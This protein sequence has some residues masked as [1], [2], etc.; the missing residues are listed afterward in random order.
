[1]T[2]LRQRMIEDMGVRNLSPRTQ[3]LYVNGVAKFAQYFGK[4]PERLGPEDIRTYQV[5]LVYEKHLSWS[6]FNGAVCALR[7]L[8][9]VTLGKDWAI[10]RIPFGKIERKLPIVL[11]RSEVEAFLNALTNI[12]YRAILMTAYATGLR[13][14]EV[15]CLRVS[16]IDSRRMVVRVEQGKGRKDRYVM[17][18]PKLLTF[19]REYYRV[20]RP[21]DW[22]FPGRIPGR[23]ITAMVVRRGYQ[24]ARAASGIRKKV[25]VRALR[26]SFATHL[27]EDGN[28][29]RTIQILLGHRSLQTTARYTHVS[30]KTVCAT[31]SPLDSL[32]G[33]H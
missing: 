3:R 16:D 22:L 28:D 18:S 23:H 21:H 20:V 6:T 12:K 14:S 10:R 17:L 26:H 25:T 4:S 11:S 27:L 31:S 15:V 9:N 1:M 24:V 33:L 19:L 32:S 5:Y 13:T 8:Y 30:A 29:L 7:F 2:P